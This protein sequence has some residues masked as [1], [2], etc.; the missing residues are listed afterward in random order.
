MREDVSIRV[1][2]HRR[3]LERE[4]EATFAEWKD[5]GHCHVVS[6]HSIADKRE[7]KKWYCAS[8]STR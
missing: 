8:R 3:K 5:H 2:G 1:S 6:V 7:R 4:G